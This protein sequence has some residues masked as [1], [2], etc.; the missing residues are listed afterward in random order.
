MVSVL[1]MREPRGTVRVPPPCA[2]QKSIAAWM[3]MVSSVALSHFALNGG[4]M[5]LTIGNDRF[6]SA[7]VRSCPLEKLLVMTAYS[8]TSKPSKLLRSRMKTRGFAVPEITGV[9]VVLGFG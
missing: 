9:T 1:D 7:A 4:N 8:M 3:A 2:A 6:N 5:A